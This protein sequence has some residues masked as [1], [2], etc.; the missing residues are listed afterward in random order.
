[1][2]GSHELNSA[3][4]V[5]GGKVAASSRN[6]RSRLMASSWFTIESPLATS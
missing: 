3:E 6:A 5:D 4:L 1:V 2:R